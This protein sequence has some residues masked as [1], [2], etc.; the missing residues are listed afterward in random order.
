[1]SW[2]HAN[3]FGERKQNMIP[4]LTRFFTCV[5]FLCKHIHTIKSCELFRR[6]WAMEKHVFSERVMWGI[7]R[8]DVAVK[9]R[10]RDPFFI[11]WSSHETEGNAC[12]I[13]CLFAVLEIKAAFLP[14]ET[15][16]Y[17]TLTQTRVF[18]YIYCLR[19]SGS[20]GFL[21]LYSM[22]FTCTC[23]FIASLE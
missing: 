19:N 23:P 5:P 9:E 7:W 1:M 18:H 22:N 21:F 4:N 15:R 16:S 3:K 13:K 17:R 10:S 14:P 20:F 6:P 8:L 11:Y 12:E 2:R